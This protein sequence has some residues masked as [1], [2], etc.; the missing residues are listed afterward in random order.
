MTAV[1]LDDL[2]RERKLL[3]LWCAG[4]GR[5]RD[6]DPLS[7]GLAGDMPVP[8][9]GKRISVRLVGGGRAVTSAP[10]LHPGGVTQYRER[11]R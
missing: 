10:E 4:C 9:V 1:T 2:A 5:E 7:L 6:V 8:D 11:I 3:W